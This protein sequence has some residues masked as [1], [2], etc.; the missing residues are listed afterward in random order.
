MTLEEQ[1]KAAAKRKIISLARQVQ[2]NLLYTTRE[3]ED[4]GNPKVSGE[5]IALL[6][7]P[8]AFKCFTARVLDQLCEVD[9]RL[10]DEHTKA[11]IADDVYVVWISK[12]RLLRVE[13]EVNGTMHL[14]SC[15]YRIC[16]SCDPDEFQVSGRMW[17]RLFTVI[18]DPTKK[19]RYLHLR[20]SGEV[21]EAVLDTF[22][23]REGGKAMSLKIS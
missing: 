9:K 4:L 10:S 17:H 6:I 11:L 20:S 18:E 7:N 2:T 16:E 22:H 3:I 23:G 13:R 8:E 21:G 12:D 5:E 14:S 1:Q 15:M 19:G